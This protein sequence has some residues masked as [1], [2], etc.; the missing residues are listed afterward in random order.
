MK[1]NIMKG[2]YAFPQC[3]ASFIAVRGVIFVAKRGQC[4]YDE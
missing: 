2:N 4:G 3:F 1:G